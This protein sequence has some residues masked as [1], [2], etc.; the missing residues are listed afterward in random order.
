MKATLRPPDQ[1][2]WSSMHK[3][4]KQKLALLGLKEAWHIQYAASCSDECIIH[5]MYE[6]KDERNS[7]T[8]CKKVAELQLLSDHMGDRGNALQIAKGI[9]R[10]AQTKLNAK[11]LLYEQFI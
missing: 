1:D 4:L 8:H 7:S 3:Q 6:A 2:V 9:P 11:L 5:Y 10:D